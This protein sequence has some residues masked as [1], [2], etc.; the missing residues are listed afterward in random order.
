[1]C[2]L[3]G[4]KTGGG[5]Q[6]RKVKNKSTKKKYLGREKGGV[7][8]GGDSE[9]DDAMTAQTETTSDT[10]FMSRAEIAGTLQQ[11]FSPAANC[12]PEFTDAIAA[13][14]YRYVRFDY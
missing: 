10:V 9:Q 3:S 8:G 11:Q 4:G 1:L 14:L 5:F 12:M 7:E 2:F 13:H 6:G